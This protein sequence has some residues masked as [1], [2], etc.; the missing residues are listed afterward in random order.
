MGAA[1]NEE[2][3]EELLADPEKFK[4]KWWQEASAEDP[5]LTREQFEVSWQHTAQLMG[6]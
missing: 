2:A 4:E 1:L 3:I 5:N 6:L